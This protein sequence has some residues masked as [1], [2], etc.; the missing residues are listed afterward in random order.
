MLL[1]GFDAVQAGVYSTAESKGGTERRRWYQGGAMNRMSV[2]VSVTCFN[3]PTSTGKSG[4]EVAEI[5]SVGRCISG[6]A[7]CRIAYDVNRFSNT[8]LAH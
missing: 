6:I 4:H 7:S 2:S 5:N 8:A 1:I 3:S